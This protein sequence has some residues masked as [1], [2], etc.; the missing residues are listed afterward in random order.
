M[1]I[2]L[3]IL[4]GTSVLF[5]FVLML[6]VF[7]IV[8]KNK[9]DSFEKIETLLENKVTSLIDFYLQERGTYDFLIN[10][11]DITLSEYL[12]I[13]KDASEF[14]IKNIPKELQKECLR[15]MD[16]DQYFMFISQQIYTNL[17]KLYTRTIDDMEI[18]TFEGNM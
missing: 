1:D 5:L 10:N 7:S 18:N 11:T 13:H 8:N 2:L 4:G 12:D 6:Y 15:Y 9:I 14:I 3:Y 16:K 17:N